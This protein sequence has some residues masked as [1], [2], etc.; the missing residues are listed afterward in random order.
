M[1]CGKQELDT[2]Q[3]KIKKHNITTIFTRERNS[4]EYWNSFKMYPYMKMTRL[5]GKM[6]LKGTWKVHFMPKKNYCNFL[7]VIYIKEENPSE[8]EK[9]KDPI[10][11]QTKVNMTINGIEVL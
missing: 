4:K 5:G 8:Q 7:L 11:I 9:L 6:E 2:Y 3:D 1:Q 10:T